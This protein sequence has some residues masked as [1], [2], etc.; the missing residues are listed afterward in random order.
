M[1]LKI[2][3]AIKGF[4]KIIRPLNCLITLATVIVGGLICSNNNNNISAKLILAGVVGFMI[5]AAGNSIND[6]YDVDIDKINRPDRPLPSGILTTKRVSIFF[7]FLIIILLTLSWLIN[8]YAFEISLMSIVLLFLY[9]Y[10]L[11]RIALIGNIIISFLTSFAF[12]FGGAVVGN[13]NNA[14][15]PAVFAF[16]INL[17]REVVKDMEDTEGDKHLGISTFPLRFGNRA[18]GY[19]IIV[20][21]V[22]LILFTLI[23]FVSYIYSI[24]FFIVVMVIVN[25]I[26]VYIIKA[27]FKDSSKKNLGRLSSMLKLNMVIGLIAIYLGK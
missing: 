3:I 1:E 26:L 16:L 9:S 11:K 8:I 27:I 18:A 24:E 7:T 4:I 6:F 21:T 23:P 17:I 25:P 10:K 22:L 14:I 13:V 2:M 20:V 19:L 15:I 5:T 12:I